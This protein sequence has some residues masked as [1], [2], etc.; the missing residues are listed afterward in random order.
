MAKEPTTPEGTSDDDGDRDWEAEARKAWK[1]RD[2]IKSDKHALESQLGELQDRITE[3]EGSTNTD[4]K[5]KLEHRLQTLEANFK[6]KEAD[7]ESKLGQARGKLKERLLQDKVT[8]FLKGL[9]VVDPDAV[10]KLTREQYDLEIDDDGNDDFKMLNG[11]SNPQAFFKS[12]IEE[13]PWLKAA[14][15]PGGTGTPVNNGSTNQGAQIGVNDIAN[16]SSEEQQKVFK[17]NPKL[18]DE[19]LNANSNLL[20]GRQ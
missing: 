6:K 19:F 15:K 7:L 3:L 9:N 13:R 20:R 5:S 18:R 17:E 1:Q 10:F 8:G 14:T 11:D 2:K 4:E 16:L 12:F